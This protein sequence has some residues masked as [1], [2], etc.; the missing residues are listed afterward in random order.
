MGNTARTQLPWGSENLKYWKICE[1]VMQT[2]VPE[3]VLEL[4][5]A[6][7]RLSRSSW[8][9]CRCHQKGWSRGF[10]TCSINPCVG[11]QPF[12]VSSYFWQLKLLTKSHPRVWEVQT[13]T[14]LNS[15]WK[16]SDQWLENCTFWS[17]LLSSGWQRH[18]SIN[19]FGLW[20]VLLSPL[21][22]FPWTCLFGQKYPSS[23]VAVF[24]LHTFCQSW[25]EGWATYLHSIL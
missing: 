20:I 10:P 24:I 8:Y 6:T 1:L 19:T 4:P 17:D 5:L 11:S 2:R 22:Y 9:E 12:H 23:S 25:W 16:P 3:G 21:C 15:L 13:Y 18:F 14:F 7:C